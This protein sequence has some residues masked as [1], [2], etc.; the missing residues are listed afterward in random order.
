MF[1]PNVCGFFTF[2]W[3]RCCRLVWQK[4]GQ[5]SVILIAFM[6]ES[7]D[8]TSKR[9]MKPDSWNN[10]SQM[11][12]ISTQVR[13]CE[14]VKRPNN[15]L[16]HAVFFV[17]LQGT[18]ATSISHGWLHD[19]AV[20]VSVPILQRCS[21]MMYLDHHFSNRTIRT[22]QCYSPTPNYPLPR[23]SFDFLQGVWGPQLRIHPKRSRKATKP[24]ANY[25]IQSRNLWANRS[26][27]TKSSTTNAGFGCLGKVWKRR[28][29]EA[30]KSL[31][32]RRLVRSRSLDA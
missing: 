26:R 18:A 17:V 23:G 31:S 8:V 12:T 25:R 22:C 10:G 30:A 11:V 4:M 6:V 15:W 19:G 32:S 9:T 2:Y 5:S 3:K 13:R 7:L 27:R 1:S 28:N 14:T 24:V 29:N 20:V 16:H 21:L